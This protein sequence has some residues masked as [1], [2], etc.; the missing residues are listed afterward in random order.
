METVI[1]KKEIN[2]QKILGFA[3]KIKNRKITRFF[4][5]LEKIE[6]LT[7][8][9]KVKVGEKEYILNH[10]NSN[11]V[12]EIQIKNDKSILLLELKYN[13]KTN[14]LKK[15]VNYDFTEIIVYFLFEFFS[16]RLENDKEFRE[17][18][19]YLKKYET[20]SLDISETAI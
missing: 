10:Y 3:P 1:L 6:E 16:D 11:E 12:E 18:R 7:Q 8:I 17:I 5:E 19:E 20:I 13:K 2:W 4:N 14:D 15:R 9:I